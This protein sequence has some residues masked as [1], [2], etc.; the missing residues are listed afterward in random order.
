MSPQIRLLFQPMPT[1][2]LR[3]RPTGPIETALPPPMLYST[4]S[5]MTLP[6]W[7]TPW[8]LTLVCA[9]GE[10][11]ANARMQASKTFRTEGRTAKAREEKGTAF[12]G[13]TSVET[14]AAEEY[15]SAPLA[16]AVGAPQRPGV[17]TSSGLH[18]GS[19]VREHGA[20][21]RERGR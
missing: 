5:P 18:M 6:R 14:R 3:I 15:L 19:A 10:P 4:S 11:L 9:H 8:S 21:A 17:V 12:I 7:C 13:G 2:M 16:A 1:P 20:G